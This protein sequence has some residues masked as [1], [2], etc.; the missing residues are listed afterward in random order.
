MKKIIIFTTFSVSLWAYSPVMPS[1]EYFIQKDENLT[2]VYSDEYKTSLENIRSYQEKIMQTYTNDFGYTLDDTLYAGFASFNNQIANGFSTQIPFNAQLNYGA[3]TGYLDYFSSTSWLKMLLVHETTHNYQVN[4]KENPL[5]KFA[6]NI[7]GN[8]PITGIGPLPIFPI[9][10]IFVGS[11]I[12]EGNAVLNESRFGIG[13]RMF[14][15]YALAQTVLLAQEGK[16]EP[17]FV[18]NNV[19][20]YP[21]REKFYLAGGHFQAYLVKKY[22][23][24]KVNHFFKTY[25]KRYFPFSINSTF[26]EH[27]GEDFETLLEAFNQMLLDK[28][29]GFTKTEGQVLAHSQ[30]FVPLSAS[31]EEIYTLISD[32]KSSPKVLTFAKDDTN[33]SV[34]LNASSLP[35]GQLFKHKSEYFSQ[36]AKQTSPKNITMGL[37]DEQANILD[38]THSKVMQGYMPDGKMVY[39]D[40]KKSLEYPHIYI[41]DHFYDTSHSRVHVDATGSLYYFKQK[42]KHRVLYKNKHKVFSYE[43]HYGYVVDVAKD[44]S[45]YFI[46]SSE[47]GAS[48]YQHKGNTIQRVAK[49]DD[50]V[51]MKLLNNKRM[52]LVT[53]DANGYNYSIHTPSVQ[54]ANIAKYTYAFE[55]SEDEKLF[56]NFDFSSDRKSVTSKHQDKSKKYHPLLELRYSSLE[57]MM[58]YDENGFLSNFSLNFTDPLM[59]NSVSLLLHTG[60]NYNFAGLA[61]ENSAYQLNFAG[62]FVKLFDYDKSTYREYGY[63]VYAEYPFVASGYWNANVKATYVKPYDSLYKEVWSTSLNVSHYK[64]F[65]LS[66]YPNSYNGLSLFAAKDRG[67]NMY[68]GTYSFMH[69]LIGQSYIGLGATY[70]KSKECDIDNEKGIKIQKFTS[71][72]GDSI[73]LEMASLDDSLF[74]KEVGVGELGLYKVFDASAYF[75]SFP[76]SIQREALYVKQKYYDIKTKDAH[77]KYNESTLGLELDLLVYHEATV[78]LQIEWV[79]NEDVENKDQFRLNLNVLF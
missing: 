20:E 28:H 73:G 25:S 10:N 54:K 53:M 35:F 32:L 21:Y 62:S 3:G 6:H 36:S 64:H 37:Y 29:K 69:D 50:V 57:Q 4:I 11:F 55:N 7:V 8:S 66:K 79:H 14:S 19:L 38:E 13:G 46:A 2:Y 33:T 31:D 17:A 59:Q 24:K 23:L 49:G 47:H 51:D 34:V 43:G 27:F 52:F 67:N 44:G 15:G 75:F 12:L 5:S 78:P 22:G 18:F 42:G 56:D 1:D 30:T 45:I 74:A 60:E 71:F 48:L 70:M 65:T 77:L 9:P 39:V 40:I 72:H 16:L 63:N 26:K 41:G 61:Y 68:G 76:L 58:T